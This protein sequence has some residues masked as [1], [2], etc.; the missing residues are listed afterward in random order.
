MY[1]LNNYDTVF[2]TG[3]PAGMIQTSVAK[4]TRKTSRLGYQLLNIASNVKCRLLAHHW[5]SRNALSVPK[6][7]RYPPNLLKLLLA[8]DHSYQGETER[9][10]AMI[11]GISD[12]YRSEDKLTESQVVTSACETNNGTALSQAEL[13]NGKNHCVTKSCLNGLRML[14]F[15]SDSQPESK[16]FVKVVR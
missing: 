14:I 2:V 8:S 10:C 3:H 16:D 13:T 1:T 7:I 6:L 5:K 11:H 4:A 12:R 9:S 15:T